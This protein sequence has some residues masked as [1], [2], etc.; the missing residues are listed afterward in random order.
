MFD[1]PKIRVHLNC[2]CSVLVSPGRKDFHI[3]DFISN[4]QR[5]NW[6][7]TQESTNL[8]TTPGENSSEDLK[9][10][11]PLQKLYT[12][13]HFER[14]TGEILGEKAKQ[15]DA[16]WRSLAEKEPYI[17]NKAFYYKCETDAALSLKKALTDGLFRPFK[18]ARAM[19]EFYILNKLNEISKKYVET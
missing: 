10:S 6:G 2:I 18:A 14:R 19:N 5:T 11:W 1:F 17:Y 12:A 3:R 4:L 13:L 8:K 15:L 7:F 9:A 16:Q